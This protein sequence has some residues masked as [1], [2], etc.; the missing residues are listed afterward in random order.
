M[1]LPVHIN[2]VSKLSYYLFYINIDIC[3]IIL[4]NSCIF[5]IALF[6]SLYKFVSSLTE[7]QQVT[8]S[9]AELRKF[10][11]QRSKRKP[12]VLFSQ[13]QVHELEQ[14]FKQQKYLSASGNCFQLLPSYTLLI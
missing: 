1:L 2:S 12:R 9:K 6:G 11:R 14:K 13:A 3:Q 4:T 5:S 10:G 7:L 8:S